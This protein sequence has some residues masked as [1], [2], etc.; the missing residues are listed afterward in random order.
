MSSFQN[1][2]LNFRANVV[3]PVMGHVA[4]GSS[5]SI[6]GIGSV[7]KS[8]LLRFLQ[9]D[10][11]R[12]EYLGKGW[13]DYLFVYIDINK[14]LRQSRWGLLELMLHQLFTELANRGTE[15]AV[16]KDIDDLHRRATTT[17]TRF[18]ALRYLDR[19]IGII[20]NQ[21][22]LKLVF[23]IDEF[24]ELCRAMS[25]SGFAALR[26]LRDEYKY[27]L[28]Y[29]V[30]TRLELKRL[31]EEASEFESFEE[32]AVPNTVWLGPYSQADAEFMLYRL[33][34]RYDLP[35]DKE[36]SLEVLKATG[37]HPGLLRE[38]YGVALENGSGFFKTLA[39]STRVQDECQRLWLSL[40]TDEQ[41]VIISLSNNNSV[42]ANQ[43]RIVDR[44]QR[45]GLVGGP[46]AEPD[47]IFSSL[48]ANYM[49]RQHSPVTTHIVVDH[50]RHAVW[51]DG[52][53]VPQLTRL[54]YELISYLDEH[55]GQTCTRDDLAEHLYPDDMSFGGKGVADNR[56]DS[57]VKRLRK[58]VE[59]D[60]KNPRYIVTVRGYGFRLSDTIV[61]K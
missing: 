50:N 3:R 43:S 17:E 31:R 47:Q 44:L 7:G 49:K 54:E 13:N 59:P 40:P 38:G 48:F 57:I 61:D 45:K 51:V 2:P 1:L 42:P 56:L 23:L 25:A 10:D 27:R 30:A 39:N 19:A 15:D 60:P 20:C 29:V 5:S 4:A 37:G 36:I 52:H 18:L 46:W 55:R 41:R 22:N 8:N 26:A 21:L 53:K 14:I 24:D 34:G 12:R 58:R 6:V 16:L 11:V 35:L 28:T 9:R 32:L 33:G